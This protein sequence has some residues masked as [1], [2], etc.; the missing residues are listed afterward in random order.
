[1]VISYDD[2][3]EYGTDS[4]GYY[5]TVT[6]YDGEGQ[7]TS[8]LQYVTREDMPVFY[9]LT[10][11]DE[12]EISGDFL[13]VLTKANIELESLDLLQND[14]VPAVARRLSSTVPSQIS[15]RM[16]TIR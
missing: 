8:A 13:D 1:M 6:G 4:S 7:I 10:G 5:S 3:Y 16:I 14:A 9:E 12:T 15:L 11:H 2:I